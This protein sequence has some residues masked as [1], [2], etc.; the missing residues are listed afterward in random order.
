MV[1]HNGAYV[2]Y[3]RILVSTSS[4]EGSGWVHNCYSIQE[5]GVHMKG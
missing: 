2:S 3:L 5:V 4:S 1:K